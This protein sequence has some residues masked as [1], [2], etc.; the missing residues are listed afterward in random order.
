MAYFGC[1]KC[2]QKGK[3]DGERIM[4]PDVDAPLRTD[5][6][7][8][9][10][11]PSSCK[12]NCKPCSLNVREH[13][14][15][16]GFCSFVLYFGPALL[17]KH[18][19]KQ[20]YT[21]FMKLSIAMSILASPK[22]TLAQILHLG[23][24]LLRRFVSEAGTL[25]GNEIYVY[26]IHSLIPLAQDVR[27]FGPVDTFST[28]PFE[29]FLGK[30]EKLSPLSKS[31]SWKVLGKVLN[32]THV[33]AKCLGTVTD[34]KASEKSA[35]PE[36]ACTMW[37]SGSTGDPKTVQ[38][39]HSCIVPN[40]LDFRK[41]F[42]I[43]PEDVIC[44]TCPLSFD[45][46]VIQIFLALTSGATLLL[47]SDVIGE[48]PSEIVKL[49]KAHK[50]SFLQATPSF[51]F[52]IR[53]NLLKK[54]LLSQDTSL[55]ILA[56]AGEE[57]PPA[58]VLKR[59]KGNGNATQMFNLYGITEVSCFATC[60]KIDLGAN[61]AV[62]L[63][64]PLAGTVLELR[65]HSGEVIEE[66]V[67]TLF[68]GGTDRRC[69]VGNETWQ[70]VDPVLLRDSGDR[71]KKCGNVFTFLNRNDSSFQYNGRKVRG[72]PAT[73]I[74][75]RSPSVETCR[76][77]FSK[78]E[79]MLYIFVTLSPGCVA[80]DALPSLTKSIETE[81]LCPFEIVV[82]SSLPLTRHGKL[83]LKALLKT[84]SE[85]MNHAAA[86]NRLLSTLW[87]KFTT[88]TTE[89]MDPQENFFQHGGS[90]LRAS[91]ICQEMEFATKH[92]LP[93]LGGKV[94][95]ETFG[96]VTAY[97]NEIIEGTGPRNFGLKG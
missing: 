57:C 88:R 96:A 97:L 38:V 59:W 23:E 54:S 79:R 49:V 22:F 70:D 61:G 5:E 76:T 95:H 80:E 90:T 42:N 29:N 56:L 17:R 16:A 89:S 67:G 32:Q 24:S 48:T 46:I 13:W 84:T 60:Q 3:H 21:H 10:W 8:R 93:L 47:P 92:P 43:T 41:I 27:Q 28:F 81:C 11:A 44:G 83:D 63:G 74:L 51:Y 26:N 4:F 64:N 36:M 1:E 71:V 18:L 68:L 53:A 69:L 31:G 9:D 2:A 62:P 94:L 12:F 35:D 6:E 55:R 85:K 39:P 40:V 19:E 33:L 58:C 25:Y 86:Y 14:K 20:F 37:T 34:T 7:F 15:V 78:G 52:T 66:G 73:A 30:L 50:V 45:P 91:T 77:H 87:K 75:L 65:K 82:F 72:D